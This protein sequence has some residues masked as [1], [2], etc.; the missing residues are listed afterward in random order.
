MEM[1][2]E[3]GQV[4]GAM[5]GI[6]LLLAAAE[7]S[8]RRTEDQVSEIV[9][10]MESHGGQTQFVNSLRVATVELELATVGIFSLFEARMQHDIPKGPFFRRL[11]ERLIVIGQADLADRVHQY[12]LAVNVLKHG[13]G[14]SYEELR[15]IP[16][17]L[18]SVKQPGEAFFEEGD[19]AE[20]EG[21]VDVR[22]SGFFDGLIGTLWQVHA[23]LKGSEY[24]I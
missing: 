9:R 3:R 8:V 16:N 12:Y 19:I 23:S 2:S 10:L 14:S 5:D 6:P 18:F 15:T 7:A 20:P 24:T 22:A 4:M 11:R 21:L 17:L 1:K 13:R